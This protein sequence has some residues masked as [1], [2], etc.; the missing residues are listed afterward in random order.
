MRRSKHNYGLLREILYDS[1][2]EK[3]RRD[4]SEKASAA[5][6]KKAA[7]RREERYPGLSADQYKLS[8]QEFKKLIDKKADA[9]V[10]MGVPYVRSYD[11]R[12]AIEVA[13][14]RTQ[15]AKDLRRAEK[16][17]RA[18]L[19]RRTAADRNTRAWHAKHASG[20]LPYQS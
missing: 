18:Y 6:T 5:A 14:G 19:A 11:W 7:S 2:R 16:R 1:L 15:E 8:G 10:A 20:K 3:Q 9:I 12:M 17:E 4:R 13:R